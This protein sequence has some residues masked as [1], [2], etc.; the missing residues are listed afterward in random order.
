[1]L[2]VLIVPFVLLLEVEEDVLLVVV[3]AQPRPSGPSTYPATQTDRHEMESA[4]ADQK[5]EGRELTKRANPS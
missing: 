1:M 3:G 5:E 2:L 4:Q